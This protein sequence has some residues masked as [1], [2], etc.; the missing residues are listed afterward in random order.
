[1]ATHGR[2]GLSHLLLGSVTEGV[3]RERRSPVLCV[4]EPEHGAAL[5]YRRVLVPTDLSEASRAALPWA[6]LLARSFQSE[7]LAVHFGHCPVPTSLSG[8]PDL[9]EEAYP[10]ESAVRSFVAPYLEGRR[11]AVQL[12]SGQPWDRLI[13]V[14]RSEKADVIVISGDDQLVEPLVR[15]AP[16]PVL[17]V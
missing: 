8:V 13:D 2:D 15:H 4:R 9:V 1:M 16:C 11:V 6:A 14:A 3:L 17:V 5:P 12:H 10:S 7:V